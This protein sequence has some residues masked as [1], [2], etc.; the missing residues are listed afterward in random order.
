[1]ASQGPGTVKSFTNVFLLDPCSSSLWKVPLLL[2]FH[3]YSCPWGP[4]PPQSAEETQSSGSGWPRRQQ[5]HVTQGC[6]MLEPVHHLFLLSFLAFL[7]AFILS[8][9]LPSTWTHLS[10]GTE[11]LGPILMNFSGV[12]N[13][14][15][16][17]SNLVVVV[18]V[19]VRNG[20]TASVWS[21]QWHKAELHLSGKLAKAGRSG[22]WHSP[23]KGEYCQ[24]R[25]QHTW[26]AQYEE[27]R[28][29]GYL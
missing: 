25:S 11:S 18:V 23:H 29:N 9:I 7:L 14:N 8:F 21:C 28:D 6:V 10:L 1:M 4:L 12:G 5:V 15:A 2:L 26:H 24:L 13:M 20:D 27:S 3:C 22:R 19:M 16:V 17:S